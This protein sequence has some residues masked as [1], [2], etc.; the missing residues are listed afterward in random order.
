MAQLILYIQW[1]HCEH[2]QL[3]SDFSTVLKLTRFLKLEC[4]F[5]FYNFTLKQ[6][7][8]IINF[9]RLLHLNNGKIVALC[10]SNVG[11]IVLELEAWQ[12]VI[13][14]LED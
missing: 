9:R 8:T 7:P 11:Y 14:I 13:D 4:F 1:G 10:L 5:F 12:I 2:R 3:N 6:Q